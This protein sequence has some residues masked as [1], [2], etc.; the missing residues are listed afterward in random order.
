MF[1]KPQTLTIYE[2]GNLISHALGHSKMN[3]EN[4]QNGSEN[5][6]RKEIRHKEK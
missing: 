6:N 3:Y 5:D 1:N 4:S 2:C